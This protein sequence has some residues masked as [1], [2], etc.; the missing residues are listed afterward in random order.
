MQV[1][2]ANTLEGIQVTVAEAS[3]DGPHVACHTEPARFLK[4]LSR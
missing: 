4:Y 3:S 1:H 2:Q